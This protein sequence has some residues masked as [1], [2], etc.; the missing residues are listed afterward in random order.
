MVLAGAHPPPVPNEKSAPWAF[1][2]GR[3]HSPTARDHAHAPIDIDLVLVDD[4]F[5]REVLLRS[6]FRLQSLENIA[7]GGTGRE[8]FQ[9]GGVVGG[10]VRII[11]IRSA[12]EGY[13]QPLQ[14]GL[15]HS[16]R[17]EKS[18]RRILFGQGDRSASRLGCAPRPTS[19]TYEN[20]G[21]G[22]LAGIDRLRGPI[23]ASSWYYSSSQRSPA[24][25]PLEPSTTD[26]WQSSPN[27]IPS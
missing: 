11:R 9:V 2:F 18:S 20:S 10:R 16:D 13:A 14:T 1:G 26:R 23:E 8:A 12:R 6:L 5:G 7:L 25:E 4:L 17:R 19:S 24:M 22:K 21:R 15:K 3:R 27:P